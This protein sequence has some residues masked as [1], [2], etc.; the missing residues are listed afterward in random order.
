MIPPDNLRKKRKWPSVVQTV[1]PGFKSAIR[2][3]QASAKSIGASLYYMT[4]NSRIALPRDFAGASDLAGCGERIV[5]K[6][7]ALDGSVSAPAAGTRPFSTSTST[8]L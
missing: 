5:S 8:V 2:A 7:C 3:T 6:A 1:A 4:P